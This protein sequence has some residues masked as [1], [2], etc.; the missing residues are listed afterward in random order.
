MGS[1]AVMAAVPL[2]L[3]ALDK[4]PAVEAPAPVERTDKWLGVRTE[5]WIPP[6]EPEK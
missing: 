4:P 5:K 1:G 2:L 3:G 6:V